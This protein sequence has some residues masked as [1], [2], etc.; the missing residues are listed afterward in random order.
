MESQRSQK[1]EGD[2]KVRLLA[3][4]LEPA[5]GKVGVAKQ[6]CPTF[7]SLLALPFSQIH[8]FFNLVPTLHTDKTLAKLSFVLTGR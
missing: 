2:K 5:L 8:P 4:G 1:G 6:D 7:L 3:S